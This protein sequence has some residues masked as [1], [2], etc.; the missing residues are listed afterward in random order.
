MIVDN[1]SVLISSINW[2]EN[3]ITRNREAGIIIEH[4]DL[5]M[6]YAEVFFYDWKIDKPLK[7]TTNFRLTDYKNPILILFIYGFTFAFIA[8]DWRKRTW[9]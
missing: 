9:I 6:Y 4:E 1:T 8:L 5:A 2:N 7:A 3:S